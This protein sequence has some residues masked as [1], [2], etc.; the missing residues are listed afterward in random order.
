MKHWLLLSLSTLKLPRPMEGLS[1]YKAGLRCVITLL[2]E[3]SLAS[4]IEYK[5]LHLES[6]LHPPYLA[7]TPLPTPSTPAK[8]HILAVFWR[9]FTLEMPFPHLHLSLIKSYPSFSNLLEMSPNLVFLWNPNNWLYLPGSTSVHFTSSHLPLNNELLGATVC[10]TRTFW[11]FVAP[12]TEF[13]V[14]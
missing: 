14:V 2:L 7:T 1:D 6:K 5:P 3:G 12:S 8:V 9:S 13:R 10:I 11:S 4:P